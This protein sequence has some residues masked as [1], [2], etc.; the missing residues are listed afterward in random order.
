MVLLPA[1]LLRAEEH[2]EVIACEVNDLFESAGISAIPPE[3]ASASAL[4]AHQLQ[5]MIASGVAM[6]PHTSNHTPIVDLC[7]KHI[8]ACGSNSIPVCAAPTTTEPPSKK[9]S[10]NGDNHRKRKADQKSKLPGP[11]ST[12]FEFACSV[13]SRM[14]QTNE[15][16]EI[17]HVRL[18]REIQPL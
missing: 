11:K 13:D 10:T 2:D 12:V 4:L 5:G 3:E 6:S 15:E 8:P 16:L 17:S 14:G 1:H 18:C 9:T 7:S